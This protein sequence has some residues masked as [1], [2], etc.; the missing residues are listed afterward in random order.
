MRTIEIDL[1]TDNNIQIFGG[2][3]GEHNE[4]ELIVTLP[5]R[6]ISPEISYYYFDFETP[7]GEHISSV[8]I[9]ISNVINNKISIKLWKQ[10]VAHYGLL[11]FCVVAA[12]LHEDETIECKGKT[13]MQTLIINKSPSGQP[14]DIDAKDNIENIHK[15]I[16]DALN[17]INLAP[18]FKKENIQ[19]DYMGAIIPGKVFDMQGTQAYV[20]SRLSDSDNSSMIYDIAQTCLDDNV[21]TEFSGPNGTAPVSG[22]AVWQA[23]ESYFDSVEGAVQIQTAIESSNAEMQSHKTNFM[24]DPSLINDVNYPSTQAVAN[25]VTGQM[26]S[27]ETALDSVIAIQNKIIGGGSV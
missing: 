21:Q 24:N 10:L 14:K 8:N 16:N 11:K 4:S 2:Y 3:Q 22:S 17:E 9:T 12:K 15:A 26:G 13:A 1:S 5:S 23:I 20:N 7:I 25:Y 18:Y 27:I 6:L 19:S